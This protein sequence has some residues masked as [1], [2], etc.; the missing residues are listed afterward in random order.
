MQLSETPVRENDVVQVCGAPCATR[1]ERL[2]GECSS[3]ARRWNG[4]LGCTSLKSGHAPPS[5]ATDTDS[6]LVRIG[7]SRALAIAQDLQ[8]RFASLNLRTRLPRA[9]LFPTKE[10]GAHSSDARC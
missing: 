6:L 4:V 1:L 9:L 10:L 5:V 7:S 8:G 3:G 2:P